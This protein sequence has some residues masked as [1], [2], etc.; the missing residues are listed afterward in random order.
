MVSSVNLAILFIILQISIVI[1]NLDSK[2]Y[3]NFFWFCDFVPFLFAMG[4]LFGGTQFVKS[5]INIGLAGQILA[6]LTIPTVR[7]SEW[8]KGKLLHGKFY[9]VTEFLIHTTALVA[10]IATYET[11]PKIISVGYS[12]ITLSVMFFVTLS[13]APRKDNVN[14]LYALDYDYGPKK[15]KRI[16]LPWHTYMWIFYALIISIVTFLIQYILYISI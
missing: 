16:K 4:F 6:L 11:A 12:A 9:L 8:K 15:P 2:Q 7:V 5:L 10:L 3:H 14:A 1:K 13:F